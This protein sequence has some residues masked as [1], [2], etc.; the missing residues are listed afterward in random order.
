MTQI[1]S[2]QMFIIRKQGKHFGKKETGMSSTELKLRQSPIIL[3][4]MVEFV[5]TWYTPVH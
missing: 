2:V 1:K 4:S 5:D 3:A